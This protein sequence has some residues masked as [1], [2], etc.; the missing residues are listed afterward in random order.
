MNSPKRNGA[1]LL[2]KE[3]GDL[4]P[5]EALARVKAEGGEA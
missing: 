4:S 3:S 1:R 5:E 2:L